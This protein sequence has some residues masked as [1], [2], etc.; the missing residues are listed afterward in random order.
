MHLSD[1]ILP[2][3]VSVAGQVAALALV[4]LTSRKL[5]SREI[6]RMGVFAAALFSVSLLHFPLGGT[7]LHPGLYGLAG[8]ILGRRVLP[9]L[10]VTLLFQSFIFQHGG[11]LALGFN[12]LLISSGALSGWL[13]WDFL[14]LPERTKAFS[15]G[16]CGILVP[17]F[18]VSC[19]FLLLDYGKGMVF[20]LTLYL[21]VAV[22]EGIVTVLVCAFFRRVQ[23]GLLLR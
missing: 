14:K 11:L 10:Y 6:P 2:A 17:A 4:T 1:G 18:L 15:C 12:T 19:L 13:L 7:S 21:P 5:Q 22:I 23:P 3:G 16:F 8:L 9:V 20:L